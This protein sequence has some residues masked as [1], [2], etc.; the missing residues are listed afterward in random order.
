MTHQASFARAEFADKKKVSR[1]EK[2]LARMEGVIPWVKL[3]AVI[4]P[5]YPKG[6]RCRPPIGL[7]R[8]LRV[9]FLQQWS[10]RRRTWQT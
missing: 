4:E 9:N 3:L 8:M 5:H 2:F 7:E 1:R 10:S 6:E